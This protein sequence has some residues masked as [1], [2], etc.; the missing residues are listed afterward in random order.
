MT[1][2]V[3]GFHLIELK[4]IFGGR[5]LLQFQLPQSFP[6]KA[7]RVRI[8][9]RCFHPLIDVSGA[10][11]SCLL[12][13][14]PLSNSLTFLK[15]LAKILKASLSREWIHGDGYE[16]LDPE[17]EWYTDY[18][19]CFERSRACSDLFGKGLWTPK[20]HYL[21]QNPLLRSAVRTLLLL[22][23]RKEGVWREVPR[24]V[25]TL[26]CKMICEE[27]LWREQRELLSKY[28]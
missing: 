11:R 24:D 8:L 5:L 27:S 15:A 26:L 18:E 7:P 6:F 2:V 10:I 14:Q 3:L 25:I 13:W 23:K 4:D 20:A 9:T 21:I 1:N 28:T 17:S 16:Y 22:H 12:E 19:N